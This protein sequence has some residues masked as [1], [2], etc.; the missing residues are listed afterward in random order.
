M[1]PIMPSHF[2]TK[3]CVAFQ[4]CALSSMRV[5]WSLQGALVHHL[6]VAMCISPIM[7]LNL[8]L[9]Q[10]CEIAL[11]GFISLDI[12]AIL[13]K[14]KEFTLRLPAG[15]G[16]MA[17]QTAGILQS[18]AL[19]AVVVTLTKDAGMTPWKTHGQLTEIGA[20]HWFGHLRL[21]SANAQHSTRSCFQCAARQMIK[22]NN[23]LNKQRPPTLHSK[24]EPLTA[25]ECLVAG[26]LCDVL[27]V[28]FNL[29][30]RSAHYVET[31]PPS[32]C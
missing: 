7:R 30:K 31:R 22:T 16:F 9:A 32:F 2:V 29:P 27:R 19:A 3:C 23:L 21:Q 15:A 1:G 18:C 26:M 12:F 14:E 13:A 6:C 25:K 4:D 11:C 5:H 17:S 28:L 20:E 24:E 10:R 8:T